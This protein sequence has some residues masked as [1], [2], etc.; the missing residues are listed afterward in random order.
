MG[1]S[2]DQV[3]T[4]LGQSWDQVGA[5]SALSWHQVENL[6]A[7]AETARSIKELMDLLE[8]KNRTKFR[9]KYITPLLDLKLL[10]MT[11]SDKPN[12]SKQQYY[13][14]AEGRKFLE[15]IKNQ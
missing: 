5:K 6:L 8:W 4:K 14:T 7:F 9:A 12:S 1:L 3:G 15:F 13:L 10:Q 2:W 11:I